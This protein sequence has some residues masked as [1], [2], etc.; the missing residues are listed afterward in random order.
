M[1]G[2]KTSRYTLTPEQRRILAEQRRLEQM[3]KQEKA[4]IHQICSMTAFLGEGL[5][6]ILQRASEYKERLGSDNGITAEYGKLIEMI[7]SVVNELHNIDVNASLEKLRQIHKTA[8]ESYIKLC[9]IRNG[10]ICL[11]EESMVNLTEVNNLDI[12]KGFQ[13]KLTLNSNRNKKLSDV[14]EMKTAVLRSLSEYRCKGNLPKRLISDIQQTTAK[15]E[16]I[17][18]I[19]F[20]QNFKAITIAPLLKSCDTFIAEF[21]DCYEEYSELYPLYTA[22]C[23]SV[24]IDAIAYEC[25]FESVSKLK[26]E[27]AKLQSEIAADDEQAYISECIDEVMQEMGYDLVGTRTVVKKNGKKFHNELYSFSEGTAVN[28][29]YSADGKITMEL[30]GLDT[31]DRLPDAAEAR[32]LC[33]DMQIFCDEYKEFERRLKERGIIPNHISILPPDSEYA[34][35]INTTDY[36]MTKDISSIDSHSQKANIQAQKRI[37][38]NG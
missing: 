14:A 18:S 37:S 26:E 1:S 19:D 28:V 6:D 2:P 24:G 31:S 4:A 5:E 36:Q 22:L 12:D 16:E 13:S 38:E 7:R 15:L 29:T 10:V 21:D 33:D 30:G 9:N 3:S 20:F 11:D 17:T 8:N 32:Q 35:I 23:D 25:C 34:Q 27:V